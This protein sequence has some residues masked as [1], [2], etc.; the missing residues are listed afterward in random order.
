M[1]VRKAR[2]EGERD[3]FVHGLESLENKGITSRGTVGE[4]YID[5]VDEEDGGRR[6]TPSFV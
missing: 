5:D 1:P 2:A 3:I 6:M 4:S